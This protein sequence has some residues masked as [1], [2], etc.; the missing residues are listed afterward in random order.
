MNRG[1]GNNPPFIAPRENGDE[2]I[3]AIVHTAIQDAISYVDDELGPDRADATRYY[4]GEPF[5]NEEKGRSQVV[6]TDVRDGIIG[7]LPSV[8]RVIHGPEHPVEFKPVGGDDV[9]LAQQATD[10][11]RYVYEEDNAGLLITHSVLKDGLLKKIGVVKWGMDEFQDVKTTKY[12]GL[13]REELA[14]LLASPNAE[15]GAVVLHDD[16][17]VDCEVARSEPKGR[18]WVMPV[19]PDD[20][21]WNREARSLDDAIIVGHRLRLTRSDLMKMG[22]SEDDLDEY[23]NTVGAAQET[24]EEI[25]RRAS[26][27]GTSSDPE[28]GAENRRILY[29]EVYMMLDM[30]ASGIAE[31][32][33]ICTIGDA[34]Q[35]V[36]NEPA[37]E[38]PFAIF[39][40]DPEPHAILGGSWYDR[41]KAPQKINSQLM[42]GML[43]SL[44]ASIF[45]R[46]GYVDGQVNV[47]DLMNT[48]IGNGIR[49]RQPGMLQVIETPFA[50]EKVMP[51][52]GFMQEVIERR[53]GQRDGAGSLDMDALQSTGKEA[54]NAAITAATAQPEL[55]ARLFIEQLMK[56]MFRGLLRAACHPLSKERIIRIRGSYVPVDPQTFNPEMDVA[57]NV[58]L[59][60]MDV[61]N[62]VAVLRDV[63]ADQTAILAQ[64][65]PENP[66][67]D[68]AMLRNAKAEILRLQGLK[69][70]DAYYKAVPPDW[71]PPPPEPPEPTPDELWIQ[72]EK[73]MAFQKQMKELAIKQDELR[74]KE[75]EVELKEQ[76][77]VLWADIEREKIERSA[78]MQRYTAD[79]D[80]ATKL[81]SERVKAEATADAIREGD[82]MEGDAE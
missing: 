77:M 29:C 41:L 19:P 9:E 7:I 28:M 47:G 72:A 74:I 48:A 61:A 38:K 49:M 64:Y 46:F 80:A 10:Y 11:V 82:A 40:P 6:M 70:V 2:D 56:P 32:R 4:N 68:L 58:A 17:T 37:D 66:V 78:E 20:F 33:R 81:Q 25:A 35:I 51:V 39:S 52:L 55:L 73:E 76:E 79:L 14:L 42:R 1:Y 34:Y 75:R 71:R 44:A 63:V 50:G 57:V 65:G 60:S 8:L 45:P 24:A 43:D 27:S 18:L 54:V 21:F 36:K 69:N 67:V 62:K 59:G 5:G 15:A 23:G 30:K 53:I 3:T 26:A 13:T 31:L 16:G 22:V 12:K